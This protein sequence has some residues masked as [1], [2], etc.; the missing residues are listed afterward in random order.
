MRMAAGSGLALHL[1]SLRHAFTEHGR[2]LLS[3]A[4]GLETHTPIAIGLLPFSSI[5]LLSYR[6]FNSSVLDVGIPL[7]SS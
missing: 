5:D 1:R 7:V 3:F 6:T 2:L 4:E